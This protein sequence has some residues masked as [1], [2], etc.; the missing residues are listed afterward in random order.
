MALSV[1]TGIVQD[2]VVTIDETDPLQSTES[3]E[4]VAPSLCRT[5]I[6]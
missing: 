3:T 2:L 1:V 6:M 4:Y 5:V